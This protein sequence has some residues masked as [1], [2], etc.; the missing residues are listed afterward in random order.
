MRL[1]GL[2][3]AGAC[4]AVLLI[5]VY[6][7]PAGGGHGTHEQLG[8]APCSFLAKTGWPC[9]TCGVT[10][11]LA[12]MAHG[13]VH[14]AWRAQP[15]GVPLFLSLV[16]VT[17]VGAVELVANR[18]VLHRLRPRLWWAIAI[19]AGVLAG[20]GWKAAAGYLEGIYPLP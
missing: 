12:A 2:V 13:Q 10:T 11:S 17:V 18:S 8:G 16:A 9:P 6:L 15:F 3:V 14:L 5:L 20:W 1:R 7:E 19:L 4:L